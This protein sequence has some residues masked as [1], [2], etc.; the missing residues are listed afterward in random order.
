MIQYMY[1]QG[2]VPSRH[3][4]LCV[5]IYRSL[6]LIA[7]LMLPLVF[8]SDI[9]LNF[10]LFVQAILGGFPR[11]VITTDTRVAEQ[12]TPVNAD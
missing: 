7:H 12:E 9:V 4:L 1:N 10:V 8:L 6:N 2:T 3:G 11:F 5:S